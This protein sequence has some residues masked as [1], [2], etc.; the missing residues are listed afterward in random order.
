[1]I[2]YLIWLLMVIAWNYGAPGATPF[3]D[4]VMAMIIGFISYK[5]KEFLPD[6]SILK[7][8][9]YFGNKKQL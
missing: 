9:K 4:V 1:M 6:L 8:N 7:K 2:V 3:E 5:L